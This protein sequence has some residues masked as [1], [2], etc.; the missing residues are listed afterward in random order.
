MSGYDVDWYLDLVFLV[1][2]K[3]KIRKE[4]IGV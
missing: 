2:E 1:L 3:D 4:I